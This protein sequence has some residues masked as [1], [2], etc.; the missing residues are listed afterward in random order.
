MAENDL[1]TSKPRSKGPIKFRAIDP[2]PEHVAMRFWAKVE[3]RG[4]DECWPWQKGL[5]T[6][7]YGAFSLPVT[8]PY[9]SHMFAA[10]RVAYAIAN[11]GL[12][13]GFM[14]CHTCD[15]TLCCNPKHLFLGTQLDNMRDMAKKGRNGQPNG[16]RSPMSKLTA[17][18]VVEIRR[19]Y[20]RQDRRHDGFGQA[21]LGRKYGVSQNAIGCVVNRKVWTHV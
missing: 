2:L 10:S 5:N 17:E 8:N 7:K 18:Q 16:E 13:A 9:G 6:S 11:N 4:E 12:V 19:I 21:A 1:T 15:N 20:I 14:V 3:R